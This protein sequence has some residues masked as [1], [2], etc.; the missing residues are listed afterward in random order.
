MDHFNFQNNELYAEQVA[1][2]EIA[3]TVGTPCYIYS[4]ETLKR[5]W[6]AFSDAF[7]TRPHKICYAVKA[8]SNLAVLNVLAE[9]GSGFDV[10]S[11]GELMRVIAAKGDPRK[12]VYSGVGKTA[13]EIAFALEKNIF[14]F[15]VESKAELQNIQKI[16]QHLDKVA[17]IA[18]RINP[19][20]D[21]RSH[22]Y[23]V[24]GLKESKFGIPYQHALSLYQYAQTQSHLKIIGLDYHI[25]SQLVELSPFVAAINKMND[26]IK[27]LLEHNIPLEFLD[28]GGGL[29]V[30]YE[31]ETPP[32]PDEY[33]KAIIEHCP[34]KE[35]TLILEP[36]RAIAANAGILVSKVIYLK[37]GQEKNFCIVDAAM[38]DLLRPSLYQAWQNIIPIHEN[39]DANT[40]AKI[41]D[42]VG[43]VCESGDFLGK[44]RLLSVKPNDYLA[45]RSAGA[46]GFVMSSNYNSR[47]RACEVMVH[48]DQ[49]QVVR[50]RESLEE[51]YHEES[52]WQ[53]S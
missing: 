38:N 27:T 29:G 23:I 41:Y 14:C 36:G 32:L 35:L 10:V 12:V 31:K 24:T 5:H 1:I 7:K 26:L 25:G 15:N 33:A 13:D 47:A 8:N 42:I 40:Q 48:H 39:A 17:P 22:P 3:Q 28:I 46:Y 6:R 9:L 4:V 34:F 53:N 2:R 50:K 11:K 16:A 44:D 19:D 51:L 43:P 30:I 20:I 37:E 45:V 21:A 18:L 49:F 52:L